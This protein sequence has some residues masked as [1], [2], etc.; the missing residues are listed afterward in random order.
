MIR[1]PRSVVLVACCCLL[2][3]CADH[4]INRSDDEAMMIYRECMA[5]MRAIVASADMPE[6]ISNASTANGNTSIAANA[7]SRQEQNHDI[8]CMRQAG[9]KN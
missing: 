5:D 8:F 9:W 1:F 7:R 6:A 2:G 4:R 3:S